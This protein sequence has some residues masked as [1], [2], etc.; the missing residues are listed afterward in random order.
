M[1]RIEAIRVCD[2]TSGEEIKWYSMLDCEVAIEGREYR[3]VR[4]PACFIKQVSKSIKIDGENDR[5]NDRINDCDFMLRYDDENFKL[6]F[7]AS[8]RHLNESKK[9]IKSYWSDIIPPRLQSDELHEKLYYIIR[10]VAYICIHTSKKA[11]TPEGIQELCDNFKYDGEV[12]ATNIRLIEEAV[13]DKGKIIGPLQSEIVYFPGWKIVSMIYSMLWC[14]SNIAD[15]NAEM[16]SIVRIMSDINQY[17]LNV[18]NPHFCKQIQDEIDSQEL[19]GEAWVI[20]FLYIRNFTWYFE[21]VSYAFEQIGPHEY[22]HEVFDKLRSITE[23]CSMPAG[24]RIENTD[25][26][27]GTTAFFMNNLSGL[28]EEDFDWLMDLLLVSTR[29]NASRNKAQRKRSL[30]QNL[31]KHFK[32]CISTLYRLIREYGNSVEE[33]KSVEKI[34]VTFWLCVE[35][36]VFNQMK[37]FEIAACNNL[38]FTKMFGKIDSFHRG[39]EVHSA[40]KLSKGIENA[41]TDKVQKIDWYDYVQYESVYF[42]LTYPI[43]K[44][45]LEGVE[46]EHFSAFYESWRMGFKTC[47]DQAKELLNGIVGIARE[48]TEK[49]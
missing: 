35:I 13:L 1:S 15:N 40:F 25:G 47:R 33:F 24:K 14:N 19:S 16:I 11:G 5:I 2:N 31:K 10:A 30:K 23:N 26:D 39:K 34:N 27:D 29:K 3:Y 42:L 4:L 48:K 36:I 49:V 21:Y 22:S 9:R 44:A 17:I 41:A 6:A 45:I 46:T 8:I 37:Q 43:K 12:F 28:S 7:L 18:S 32:P 38:N 20:I